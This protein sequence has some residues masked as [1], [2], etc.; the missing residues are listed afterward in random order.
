M[1]RL[2]DDAAAGVGEVQVVVGL[3]VGQ[4]DLDAA[5]A[6]RHNSIDVDVTWPL[7][8]RLHGGTTRQRTG[9]GGVI[10]RLRAD[11]TILSDD[12]PGCYDRH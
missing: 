11:A 7:D 10:V 12:T 2:P 1:R 4:V 6:A 3:E 5:G 9:S 8:E